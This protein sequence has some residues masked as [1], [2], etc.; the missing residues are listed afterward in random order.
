MRVLFVCHA[1]IARS[2][3]AAALYRAYVPHG[4]ADSAGVRVERPG[5]TL[6]ELRGRETQHN[7][8]VIDIMRKLGLNIGQSKRTQ[9][10]ASMLPNY[11]YIIS[12][13]E[14]TS[15]PRYLVA[16]DNYT[17]WD[18][19]DPA[20][21][22]LEATAYTEELIEVALLEFLASAGIPFKVN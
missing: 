15:A 10:R 4:H 21:Y 17:Y 3:M 9:L 6:D 5:E 19:T 11:D 20:R 22:G 12:M 13:V 18:I 16:A 1:N 2:Q 14:E 7:P 8:Y